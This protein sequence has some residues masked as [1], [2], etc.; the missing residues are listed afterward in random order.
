MIVN[1]ILYVDDEEDIREIAA[2]ALELDPGFEVRTCASGQ[3]AVRVAPV[4]RPDLVLLDIMMP[5]MDGPTTFEQLRVRPE[6][7]QVPVVFISA[8]TRTEEMQRLTRLGAAGV[9]A[10]PFDPMKLAAIARAYLPA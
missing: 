5:G 3:E 10:K 9:I 1:R 8:R 6:L 2:M 7:D 4:W